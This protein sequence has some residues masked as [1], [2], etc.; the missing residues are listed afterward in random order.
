MEFNSDCFSNKLK[1][2]RR[3][4]SLS[5]WPLISPL[6][7]LAFRKLLMNRS[8]FFGVI[9]MAEIKKWSS[10][11]PPLSSQNICTFFQALIPLIASMMDFSLAQLCAR[12]E[13]SA[14]AS[15]L[16]RSTRPSR[17]K[18]VES[19]SLFVEPNLSCAISRRF[20]EPFEHRRPCDWRWYG[21]EDTVFERGTTNAW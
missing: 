15:S 11:L 6:L 20:V 2:I 10:L 17:S 16:S 5:E 19:P 8:A 12:K 4:G 3:P 7:P 18:T 13:A 9:I 1:K 14:R 21:N